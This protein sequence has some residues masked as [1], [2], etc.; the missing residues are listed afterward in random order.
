VPAVVGEVT[1]PTPPLPPRAP[2][3]DWRG[4]GERGRGGSDAPVDPARLRVALMAMLTDLHRDPL[5]K[6]WSEEARP[7]LLVL[8]PAGA[9]AAEA[10]TANGFRRDLETLFVVSG[11]VRVISLD[12]QPELAERY[13]RTAAAELD[14]RRLTDWTARVGARYVALAELCGQTGEDSPAFVLEVLD[15]ETGKVLFHREARLSDAGPTGWYPRTDRSP[16]S[17]PLAHP[18][19]PPLFRPWGRRLAAVR[20]GGRLPSRHLALQ[21]PQLV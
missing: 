3:A 20:A 7:A 11:L 5:G 8:A 15:G 2:R 1:E 10:A 12:D 6:R 4:C 14:A 16:G 19:R 17:V 9:T 18:P 13:R 21:P